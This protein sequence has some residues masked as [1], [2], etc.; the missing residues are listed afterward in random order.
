MKVRSLTNRERAGVIILSAFLLVSL[1]A[2]VYLLTTG[3]T[4]PS[5][6]STSAD[7]INTDMVSVK[8][9]SI[10]KTLLIDGELRAVTSRTVFVNTQ[11]ESKITFLPP[12]GSIVKAGDR[13]VELDSTTIHTKIKEIE[14]QIIAAENTIV[15]TRSTHESFLR[16]MEVQLSQLWLAYEQAKIKARAPA[17]VVSRRDYQENLLNLE[18]TR[19]EY[20]NQIRKIEQKKKEQAAEIQV[21]TID[22]DKLTLQLKKSKNNLAGMTLTAPAEGMVIYNEHWNEQRKVQIGDVIWGG[23]PVVTLPDLHEMEVTAAVN[24]VDGP[25]L[26]IGQKATIRLD[27]YPHIEI[28]GSV[29]AI[30]Q[31]AVKASWRAKAKIFK[32]VI[33]LDKTVPEIMKPGMSAQVSIVLSE[34]LSDLIVPRSTIGFESDSAGVVRLEGENGNRVIAV[35]IISSDPFHYAIADNGALKEGDRILSR[36]PSDTAETKT[37]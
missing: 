11:E 31:T 35:T 33:S 29:K 36:W 30:A 3:S 20:E 23:F 32:V 19:T 12:E 9:G 1:L 8:R 21:S 5:I 34:S 4:A 18:K 28:T 37:K 15:K 26:S 6:S 2:T 10:K 13:V 27:S 25:K 17:E 14:E 24:E 16:D 7:E 22:K